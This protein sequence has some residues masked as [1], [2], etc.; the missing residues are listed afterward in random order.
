MFVSQNLFCL[1]PSSSAI[2]INRLHTRPKTACRG[3]GKLERSALKQMYLVYP[4][5]AMH[6]HCWHCWSLHVL[7][8]HV[9]LSL[10]LTNVFV[11]LP[12]CLTPPYH[13]PSL[14]LPFPST[15][16]PRMLV[17]KTLGHAAVVFAISYTT[18]ELQLMRV[19]TARTTMHTP[20]ECDLRW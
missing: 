10:S 11:V 2:Y 1:H 4:T 5:S 3:E 6:I 17:K 16:T 9:F 13:L 7:L 12:L 20:T 8:A 15:S 19:Y 18:Q 14:T